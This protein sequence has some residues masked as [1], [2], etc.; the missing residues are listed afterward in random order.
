MIRGKTLRICINNETI[1]DMTVVGK[2][3]K[4]LREIAMFV[5]M[6]RINDEKAPAKTTI[7]AIDGSNKDRPKKRWKA[8]VEKDM[9]ATV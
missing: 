3:E 7:F 2:L 9:L 5:H 4:L 6:E 1:C 8:V